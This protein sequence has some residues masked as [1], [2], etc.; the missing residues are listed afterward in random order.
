MSFICDVHAVA[1][2]NHLRCFFFLYLVVN[3]QGYR[4]D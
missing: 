1:P 3:W 2:L 4:F